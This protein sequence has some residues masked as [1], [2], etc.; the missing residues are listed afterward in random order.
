MFCKNRKEIFYV[1][2]RGKRD[3]GYIYA[4]SITM[5]CDLASSY[6]VNATTLTHVWI[7]YAADHSLWPI[8][9][10]KGCQISSVAGDNDHCKACPYHAQHPSTETTWST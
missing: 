6:D 5:T 7:F 4:G 8:K 2:L 1:A 3:F 9:N 10:K